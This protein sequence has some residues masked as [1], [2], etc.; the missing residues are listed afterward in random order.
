[1]TNT[2]TK[3]A[4]ATVAAAFALTGAAFADDATL[5]ENI[6]AQMD[7]NQAAFTLKV[8]DFAQD[9]VAQTEPANELAAA[10][11][12]DDSYSVASR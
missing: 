5:T 6:Y 2:F 9:R 10:D 8:N 12:S 4:A 11:E 1:M 3:T 7:A